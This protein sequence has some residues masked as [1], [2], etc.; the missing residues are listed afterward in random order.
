MIGPQI[1]I[2]IIALLSKST[3]HARVL[4]ARDCSFKWPAQEGDTCATFANNWSISEAD[5]KSYNPGVNCAALEV[6]KEYCVEWSGTPPNQPSTPVSTP[7]PSATSTPK[8]TITRTTTSAVTTR[9]STPGI[10][11]TPTSGA[12]KST[13]A[14]VT[15]PSPIQTG[16]VCGCTKFYKVAKDDG[17][18]AIANANGI[19][20]DDLYTWNPILGTDCKNLFPDT[21]ICIGKGTAT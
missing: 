1:F 17:C 20:V 21:Y 19:T 4:H 18:W 9:S 7:T 10:T 14:G 16:L 15:T 12:C 5:F 6:G 2:E 11:S 13:P 8:V 3:V